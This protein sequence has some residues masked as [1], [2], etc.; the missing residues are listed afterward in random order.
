MSTSYTSSQTQTFTFTH[1]KYLASKVATDLKR[2]QRLYGTPNDVT[3]NNYEAELTEYLRM[4]YL[5]NVIYGFQRDGNWIEP[6]VQYTSSE[7]AGSSSSDDDPGKIR[8]G[9][10]IS[11]AY[12]TS[13]LVHNSKYSYLSQTEK[14]KFKTSLPFQRHGAPAP[15]INGYLSSDKTYSS[16]G[17]SLNR[18][19]VKNY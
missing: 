13:Y 7:L 6:T 5:D 4:G 2:I 10:N 11:G 18:S 3:I 12:F 9:A 15:G 16:G 8:P 1:A 14:D 19:S 17:Q